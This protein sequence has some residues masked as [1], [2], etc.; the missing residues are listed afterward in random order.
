MNE[1]FNKRLPNIKNYDFDNVKH[2]NEWLNYQKLSQRKFN[3]NNKTNILIIGNSHGQD[4][5]NSMIQNKDEIPQS[6]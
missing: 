3:L 1:G 5:Y 2:R 6:S 4:I